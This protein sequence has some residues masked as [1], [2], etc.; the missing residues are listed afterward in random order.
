MRLLGRAQPEHHQSDEDAAAYD[1]ARRAY[2]SDKLAI[3]EAA[4]QREARLRRLG[5]DLD[6][7]TRRRPDGN[8]DASH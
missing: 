1:E 2:Q 8:D 5:Y 3:F 7:V 4:A 6:A